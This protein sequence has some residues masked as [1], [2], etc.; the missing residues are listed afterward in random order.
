MMLIVLK[1]QS[2]ID[3]VD[4]AYMPL[5]SVVVNM[6]IKILEDNLLEIRLLGS[7]PRGCAIRELS[8]ID[9]MAITKFDISQESKLL[10]ENILLDLSEANTIVSKIDVQCIREDIIK[11]YFDLELIIKTDS[12]NLYGEDKYTVSEYSIMNTELAD[13]W[14]PNI[15]FVLHNYRNKL[16]SINMSDTEIAKYSRL[17]GKDVMKCFQRRVVLEHG[18]IERTI[19]KI[20]INLKKYI[21]DHSGTFEKLW[22]LYR[23]PTSNKEVIMTVI[24]ECEQLK[25]EIL[26]G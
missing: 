14:N 12:I 24:D 13:L 18:F 6:L 25:Y 5:I 15:D 17:T 11:N 10:L 7:V 23:L 20:Y 4:Q 1:N 3:H 16:M 22:R 8:D 2:S 26:N 9:F 21:P 19:E